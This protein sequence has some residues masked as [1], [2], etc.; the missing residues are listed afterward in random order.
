M[1]K[2]LL[3]TTIESNRKPNKK[4]QKMSEAETFVIGSR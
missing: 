1:R 4:E 2:K 3:A